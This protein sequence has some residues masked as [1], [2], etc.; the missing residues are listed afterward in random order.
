M[1]G[2]FE[3][4]SYPSAFPDTCLLKGSMATLPGEDSDAVKKEFIRF[5]RD[6]VADE[7]WLG[8][9]PPE[10]VYAGYFAEPSAISLEEPIVTML[11][12]K[13][14]E[15][16]QRDPLISGREGAADIRFLNR[17]GNTPTVIFGPGMTEQMHANHEWVAA[18]DLI[19]ATKILALTILDWCEV[20]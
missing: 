20:A 17:Y 10:V 8:A 18:D 11:S 9:H 6:R 7:P 4:G 2:V 19:S 12:R 3:S 14:R 1:V 16:M 5:I 15:V 13:F